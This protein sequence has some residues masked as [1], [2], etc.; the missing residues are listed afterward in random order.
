MA[1]LSD[2]NRRAEWARWMSD[3]SSN[4]E[5]TA[6]TKADLLA[7]VNAVDAWV[8]ANQ[9]SYNNALPV[10]AR[11]TLTPQQKAQ[12]L[13]YVIRRRYEVT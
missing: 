3:M 9:V 12:L 11:T 1:V 10:A 2:A 5:P 4:R 13:L 7:A 8:D 6:I